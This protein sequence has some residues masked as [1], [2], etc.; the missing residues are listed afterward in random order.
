[1]G[2]D[3]FEI[4]MI[5]MLYMVPMKMKVMSDHTVAFFFSFLVLEQRRAEK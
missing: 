2:A 4:I 3:A 1:M 5:A